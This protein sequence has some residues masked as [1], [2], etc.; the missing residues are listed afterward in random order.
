MC[1]RVYSTL[2]TVF[3]V[4]LLYIMYTASLILVLSFHPPPP[5]FQLNSGLLSSRR[6]VSTRP[7]PTMASQ[8]ATCS[9]A[10]WTFNSRQQSPC[11]V[12]SALAG[13]CVGGDFTLTA[14]QPDYVYLG[15]S[16]SAATPCRCS[17]VYYS[18]LSAC[19]TCQGNNFIRWGRYSTNCSTV[20]MFPRDIPDNIAVPAWAYMDVEAQDTFNLTLAQA[21]G[22]VESTAPVQSTASATGSISRT[23]AT[24]SSTNT[25]ANPGS[26]AGGSSTDNTEKKSN[27]GAIAGGVV[28]GIVGLALIA[29]L[30]F[31][32]LRRNKKQKQAPSAMYG[33]QGTVSE[34]PQGPASQ[35]T[36]DGSIMYS[37]GGIP[38]PQVY[39]PNNPATFPTGDGSMSYTQTPPPGQPAGYGAPP[40]PGYGQNYG[41][42][43]NGNYIPPHMTG[44]SASSGYTQPN[45]AITQPNAPRYTGAPE[46]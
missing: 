28:G 9:T 16:V 15:P 27:A 6:A 33:S 39:D 3:P 24:G 32:L 8:M 4:P 5:S 29:G 30:I 19:A 26:T 40:S 45:T 37:H 17:S 42:Q 14:L 21:F 22:G 46:L 11:V 13:A 2:D 12:G 35:Y 10:Q 23:S 18:M 34:K 31:F 25:G 43:P 7:P 20:Y 44:Q 36:G 38:A 41:A 1:Y